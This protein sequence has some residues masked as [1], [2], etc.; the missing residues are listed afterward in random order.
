M[1]LVAPSITPTLRAGLRRRRAWIVIAAALVLG[2]LVVLVVQGGIRAPGAVLGADNPAPPGSKALVEVLRSHGIDVTQ[3]RGIDAAVDAAQGGATVF[4]YDELALLDA[5]RLDELASAVDRLVVAEP[6]FGTLEVLAPGVRLGGTATGALDEVACDVGA[7]ERAGELSDGQRLLTVDDD[8]Q[9]AGFT[10]CFRDGEFG[11]AV[12]SGPGRA[13][14]EL[15][16]VAATTVFTNDRID[17]AGNA[18]LAIGLL[19]AS[20]RLVW[21][22]PGPGDADAATAPT[23]AELTPGWVSPV[24]VLLIAV[25]VAAG[26]WRGRRFGPLVVENLPVHV[27]AGETSE[28]RA[29]LYAR[30]A[31]RGHAADQ[32]RIGAIGRIAA[33]LR[34]PRSSD[35]D[36]LA[37]A[38]AVATGRDA[39]SVAR[40]LVAD[41]PAGDREFVELAGEH[42]RLE[43]DVRGSIRPD[44]SLSSSKGAVAPTGS[45][46][47]PRASTG[48][49]DDSD[50]PTGRRP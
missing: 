30:N 38:A 26:V 50:R 46:D 4:L 10:G 11:Y 39:A 43:R 36:T 23:L 13:G 27:P 25:V 7:A 14:G 37:E 2:A 17:E 32:L 8:A 33:L 18:A 19:G 5:E 40:L 35:V 44:R 47:D 41:V 20:D 45:A 21:Y 16:L 22:L 49:A 48:S 3:A 1:T 24:I 9:A 29:R 42:D 12:V 34:L 6:A 31:A 15:T 28:G